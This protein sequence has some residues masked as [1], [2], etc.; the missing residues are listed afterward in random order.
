MQELVSEPCSNVSGL[1]L[2]LSPKGTFLKSLTTLH[3]NTFKSI[4]VICLRAYDGFPT[5]IAEN[6]YYSPLM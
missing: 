2:K 1:S 3:A 6:L 5:F 4:K